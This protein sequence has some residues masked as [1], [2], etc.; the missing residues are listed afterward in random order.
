MTMDA[1]NSSSKKSK[2]EPIES[3]RVDSALYYA[4][5]ER[6]PDDASASFGPE[7]G[8][9][10]ESSVSDKAFFQEEAVNPAA[11]RADEEFAADLAPSVPRS[12]QENVDNEATNAAGILGLAALMMAGLSFFLLPSIL[13]PAAAVIGFMAFVKGGRALGVWAIA[14]GIVSFVGFLSRLPNS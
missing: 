6:G 4:E 11:Q 1:N 2:S 12:T 14:L 10:S 13:G 9:E 3:V 5:P 8:F 7:T